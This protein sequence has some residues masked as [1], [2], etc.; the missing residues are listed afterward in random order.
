MA[1]QADRR[2]PGKHRQQSSASRGAA[3]TSVLHQNHIQ[4]SRPMHALDARHFNVSGSARPRNPSHQLRQRPRLLFPV[5]CSL[6]PVFL[7]L[8]RSKYSG[9]VST[10]WLARSTHRCQSG[11][12]VITRRPSAGRV[13]Q[14]DGSRVGHAAESRRHHA[15]GLLN[16][17]RRQVRGRYSIPIRD[18]QAASTT[19]RPA[20]PAAQQIVACRSPQVARRSR[21]PSSSGA[22]STTSASYSRRRSMISS[23]R[24]LTVNSPRRI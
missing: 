3:R 16:L 6:F 12:R 2:C 13:M 15:F 22:H 20:V 23:R 24:A 11:S 17:A 8:Q 10:T 1:A 21:P 14:H 5:P 9:S 18:F 7:F 19:T 4:K